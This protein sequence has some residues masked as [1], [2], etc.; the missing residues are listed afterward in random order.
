MLTVVHTIEFVEI[1]MIN[2]VWLTKI[3]DTSKC[4][5]LLDQGFLS[6]TL[7]ETL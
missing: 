3:N 6:N 5:V 2:V 7:R 4:Y 1:P